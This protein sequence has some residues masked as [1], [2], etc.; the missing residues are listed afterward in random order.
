MCVSFM[1]GPCFMEWFS[2]SFLLASSML[3]KRKLIDSLYMQLYCGCLCFVSLLHGFVGWSA[4]YNWSF[5]VRVNYLFVMQYLMSI[6]VLHS[7]DRGRERAGCFTLM[8]PAFVW[9]S[10]FCVP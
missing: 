10:V 4:V 5:L 6:L 2:V 1:L 8:C 9:M 3:R 7:R